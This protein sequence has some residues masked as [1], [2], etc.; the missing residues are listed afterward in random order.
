MP[1]ITLVVLQ[2]GLW[3]KSSHMGYIERSL[4]EKLQE[5]SI[6]VLNSKVNEGKYTYDGVDLCGQRLADK[7]HS[8]VQELSKKNKSVK[9][10][11]M[12]GYSL[13]GLIARYAIGLLD[14]EGFFNHVKPGF[15]VTFATPHLG[16]RRP[17]N[18]LFS[19]V[20]NF[21]SGKL[22]SRTGEQLQLIDRFED[23]IPLLV[24]L[25]SPNRP[26]YQALGKF[27]IIR[28]YANVKNDRTVPYWTAALMTTEY[29]RNLENVDLTIDQE[30][31]SIIT[32]CDIVDKSKK[33]RHRRKQ[34]MS[35]SIRTALFYVL[36]PIIFP[37]FITFALLYIG[38]QG[39][40]SRL[41]VSKALRSA[42]LPVVSGSASPSLAH[43]VTSSSNTSM[44]HD[45]RQPATLLFGTLDAMNMVSNIEVTPEHK[46]TR[47]LGNW[48]NVIPSDSMKKQS[49][50]YIF[51]SHTVD[52]QKNLSKLP[53][54]TVLV[55][56]HSFNAH[57]SIVCRQGIHTT[58]DGKAVIRHFLDTVSM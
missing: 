37:I 10:L 51:D 43:S 47:L 19:R 35:T 25:A 27:D 8:E 34:P 17:E 23:D 3:G 29:F 36:I 6:V 12:I 5:E 52:I 39:M 57:G 40:M 4:R 54:Q 14:Q 49:T 11:C 30:Y 53:W 38:I 44:D 28:T 1:D 32:G 15:F 24:I 50:Q 26:Y 48:C 20:F 18:S 31:P 22:V 45:H 13:G 2:H 41:R 21:F 58:S 42:L 55:C 33:A 9:K 16:V 7:I 46:S 56:L